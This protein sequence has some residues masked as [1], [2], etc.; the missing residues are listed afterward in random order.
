LE[1]VAD[2]A[3]RRAIDDA[4]VAGYERVPPTPS[5]LP[6]AEASLRAAI[7]DEPW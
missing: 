2:A 1:A 6:A 7:V 3:R 5:E 4:V